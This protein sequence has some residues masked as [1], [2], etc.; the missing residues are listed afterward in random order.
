MFDMT[1]LS[2]L[3]LKLAVSPKSTRIAIAS[4][5]T[6]RV[7][8]LDADAFLDPHY[9]LGWGEGVPGD[10]AFLDG[11]GWQYYSCERTERECVVLEPIE[12]P[13]A[14]VVYE[15]EFQ[16]ENELWGWCEQGLVRWNFGPTATRKRGVS[17]LN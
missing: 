3:G 14:G 9:S 11:P 2:T 5:K 4:W 15:L 7:W 8:A 1:N 12:L 6:V 13:S 16:G 10:Y 17:Q